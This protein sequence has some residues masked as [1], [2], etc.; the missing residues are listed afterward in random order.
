MKKASSSNGGHYLSTFYL[1]K[2]DPSELVKK[3]S[4]FLD[5]QGQKNDDLNLESSCSLSAGR[6][7]IGPC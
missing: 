6:L 3:N 1:I 7:P 4:V 2:L 5:L